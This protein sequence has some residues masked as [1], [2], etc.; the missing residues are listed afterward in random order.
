MIIFIIDW[1]KLP[2]S[3]VG[4]Q[5]VIKKWKA[6][7]MNYQSSTWCIQIPWFTH[8]NWWWKISWRVFSSTTRICCFLFYF[9]KAAFRQE[10]KSGDFPEI[11]W[12]GCMW[13]LYLPASRKMSKWEWSSKN[14]QKTHSDQV[15]EL[16][17]F[18]HAMDPY[19]VIKK[20]NILT[21][22]AN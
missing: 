4:R 15:G 11:F 18:K 16:T 3:W 21:I 10:L 22:G 7:A 2:D 20:L 5:S 8:I 17:H 6:P 13:E 14:V 1:S 9:F 19:S 12:K